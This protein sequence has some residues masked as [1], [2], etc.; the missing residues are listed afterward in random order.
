MQQLA[1][2]GY[3]EAQVMDML[4]YKKGMRNIKFKYHLLDNKEV[5]KK[6][7][8]YILDCEITM[9]AFADIK[10]KATMRM[11]EDASIN[12]LSD[13]IQV[14]FMLQV[15]GT[16]TYLEWSLGIFLL[17]SSERRN[18]GNL[19][20]RQV[21]AYDGLQVL[22]DDK[23]VDTYTIAV[24]TSY[25]DA[26]NDILVGAG[27]NKINVQ[28]TDKT[29]AITKEY[30][31]GTPKL[32]AINDLLG[33]INYTQLWVDELGFYTA[34]PYVIPTER[35]IDYSYITDELSILHDGAQETLDTFNVPNRWVVIASNPET[36]PLKSVYTNTNPSSP[37]STASRGRTI[38]DPPIYV[39]NVADQS[40]LDSYTER[41]AFD[42]SQIYGYVPFETAIMPM[43]SYYDLVHLK[44]DVLN[45]DDKYTETEWRL[46]CRI[47]GR[48]Q[49]S[50][51]KLVL[52]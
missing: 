3:T 12:W 19:I 28:Y 33:E 42:A 29:L 1:Q 22:T 38:V 9:S 7:L 26:I 5:F 45:I 34:K 48:M 8:P 41:K 16:E 30:D 24:N 47:G 10:R 39:N 46:P 49:H 40:T 44:Y 23:F 18:D 35:A 37:T 4:H 36:T 14:F 43:H 25:F 13:R 50:A 11:K 27:I 17:S 6:E 20:I 32:K 21:T 15:P 31:I 51:R 52:I 2:G